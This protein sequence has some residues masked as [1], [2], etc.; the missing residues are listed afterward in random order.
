MNQRGTMW[1]MVLSA[2]TFPVASAWADPCRSRKSRFARIRAMRGNQ[3][4]IRRDAYHPPFA[5]DVC[6]QSVQV[7]APVKSR[8]FFFDIS[9]ILP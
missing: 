8:T 7:A 9:S 3:G 4:I 6:R 1:A 2:L 5:W